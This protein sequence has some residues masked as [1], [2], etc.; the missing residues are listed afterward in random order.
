MNH[1][2]T[3]RNQRIGFDRIYRMS[4]LLHSGSIDTAKAVSRKDV[5]ERPL[6]FKTKT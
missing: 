5:M 2:G 3:Q 4:V 1:R 6:G